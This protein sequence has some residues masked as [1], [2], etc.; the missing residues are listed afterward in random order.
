[1]VWSWRSRARQPGALTPRVE[2]EVRGAAT[3]P[4]LALCPLQASANWMMPGHAETALPVQCT[5]ANALTDMPRNNGATPT[6]PVTSMGS[7]CCDTG[8]AMEARKSGHVAVAP[9]HPSPVP[10]LEGPQEHHEEPSPPHDAVPVSAGVGTRASPLEGPSPEQGG[11]PTAGTGDTTLCP[12]HR[13]LFLLPRDP[14]PAGPSS[15]RLWESTAETPRSTP[16]NRPGPAAAGGHREGKGPRRLGS[17][18]PSQDSATWLGRKTVRFFFMKDGEPDFRGPPLTCDGALEARGR[19]AD[20][21]LPFLDPRRSLCWLQE[22]LP[23]WQRVAAVRLPPWASEPGLRLL[24]LLLKT[25]GLASMAPASRARAGSVAAEASQARSPAGL[26][27]S[28]G[29]DPPA[30]PRL[31][32]HGGTSCWGRDSRLRSPGPLA[33]RVHVS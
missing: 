9:R 14:G 28:Y 19:P 2:E 25:L 21:R 27:L 7:D 30:N 1:M 33:D 18:C 11:E 16:R 26:G 6:P 22:P 8:P 32:G 12:Q 15:L 3:S 4:A 17:P 20:A 23:G 31:P 10:L 29:R 5:D 13:R 24:L